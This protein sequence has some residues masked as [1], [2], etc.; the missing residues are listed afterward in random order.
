MNQNLK[1]K[2]NN[3]K[4]IV[5]KVG[6]SRVS[7]DKKDV[8]DFL[9]GLTGSIRYLRDLGKKVI[10]VSSGA[11][12]QGKIV[13]EVNF[14]KKDWTNI[15]LN[16]K[17]ALA[18]LGQNRLMDLY[19]SFFQMVNIPIAQI[20]FGKNDI[21]TPEGHKNLTNT[22]DTILNWGVLPI[23]NENDSIATE[24]LNLGDNDL[25]SAMVA[26]LL[27]ADILVVLTGVDGFL[28]NNHI[29]PYLQDITNEDFQHAKGPSGPGRG[30]MITKLKA[31]KILLKF[32][33]LTAI[34]NGNQQENIRQ[35][36]SGLNPGTIVGDPT[37]T[38]QILDY[39]TWKQRFFQNEELY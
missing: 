38:P 15:S 37:M 18:A 13:Y 33:I 24:E 4:I 28:K 36:F 11:I 22:F 14:G 27:G 9:Y 20:L 25:L 29:V 21:L 5:I 23:V 30:G 1:L 3:S 12:A 19:D 34:V 39:Q 10:L 17:Q 8:N 16:E 31:A 7:G 26:S 2:L 32:G 35:L 6:S